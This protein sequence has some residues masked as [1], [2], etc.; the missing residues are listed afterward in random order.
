MSRPQEAERANLKVSYQVAYKTTERPAEHVY[1]SY[2]HPLQR[3]SAVRGVQGAAI[4]RGQPNIH[5]TASCA[6]CQDDTAAIHIW[7]NKRHRGSNENA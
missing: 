7:N 5:G 4:R 2:R 6:S 1:I 3:P